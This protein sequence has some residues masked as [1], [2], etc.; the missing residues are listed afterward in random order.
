MFLDA[1]THNSNKYRQV[2]FLAWI[3]ILF[4]SC[5]EGMEDLIPA[6][7]PIPEP[8]ISTSIAPIPSNE[9]V[10]PTPQL[11]P[12]LSVSPSPSVTTTPVPSPT[13]SPTP[14]SDGVFKE[15]TDASC[16]DGNFKMELP[17]RSVDYASMIEKVLKSKS[18]TK[19]Q[20][21]NFTLGALTEGYPYALEF[22][23]PNRCAYNW[24]WDDNLECKSSNLDCSKPNYGWENNYGLIVHECHH[25][26]QDQS[27]YFLAQDQYMP[28]PK[29][30]YF[31]RNELTKDRFHMEFPEAAANSTYFNVDSVTGHQDIDSMYDEWVSYIHSVAIEY[32]LYDAHRDSKSEFHIQHMLNFAWAAPRYY[33]WAK[34]N[35]PNDFEKLINEKGLRETTL[36]F[37][38][39]TLFLFDAFDNNTSW[40]PEDG[41]YYNPNPGSPY[42]WNV[43][44]TRYIDLMRHPDLLAM[45][46]DI[47]QAHGCDGL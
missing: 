40:D 25:F 43:D 13:A 35:R 1:L 36:T 47:R 19:Y 29:N 5:N 37:W 41:Q 30:R 28:T 17:D 33:L 21:V 38:G 7:S 15:L 9:P 20:M 3:V 32:Q 14:D 31:P 12:V 42:F 34:E 2:I 23:E 11:T 45:M 46:N 10:S 18:P 8:S 16:I 39:A 6:V 44:E 26:R 4:N 27:R 22:V 24:W